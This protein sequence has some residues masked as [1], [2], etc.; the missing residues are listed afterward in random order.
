[1]KFMRVCSRLAILSL[2]AAAFAGLTAIY[3]GSARPLPNPRLRAWKEH[4]PSAPDLGRFPELIGEGIVVAIYAVAGRLIFRLRL[5]PRS[6]S[7]GDPISL[8]LH[9][10]QT[11]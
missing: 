8:G 9:G 5:S 7:E 11:A 3:G 4:R 1:M 6:R 2:A 10:D